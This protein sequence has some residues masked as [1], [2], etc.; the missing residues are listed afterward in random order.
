MPPVVPSV[1]VVVAPTQTV[2]APPIDVGEGLTVTGFVAAQLPPVEN[3]IIAVPA[4][5]PNTTPPVEPTDATSVLLLLHVP[6]DEVS[7][8]VA[9]DPEQNPETPLIAPGAEWILTT[10][11]S[12][13]PDVEVKV[14]VVDPCATPLTV[15]VA[16]P[17]VATLL[18][19][20][21]QVPLLR[22]LSVDV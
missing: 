6:P 1:S 3:V 8:N 15:P 19:E 14:T 12:I 18:P 13:Q 7:L 9:V 10:V 17:T 4:D 11:V 2:D 16:E 21:L 20:M 5:T 22:S